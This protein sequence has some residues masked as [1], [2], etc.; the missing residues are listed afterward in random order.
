MLCRAAPLRAI[1]DAGSTSP[2][3]M[4]ISQDARSRRACRLA[5]PSRSPPQLP[6]TSRAGASRS[7][8]RSRPAAPPTRSRASSARS[9]PSAGSSPSSSR[10]ARARP[11]PPAAR[12]SPTPR[13]TATPCSRARPGPL[14]INRF[15]QKAF[16]FDPLQL[17]PITVMAGVP[18]VLAI[19]SS[20]PAKSVGE[21][22]AYAKQA[23]GRPELRIAGAGLDVA[24]LGRAVPEPD[25][26]SRWCM[27]PTRAARPR[28]PISSAAIST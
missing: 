10:T 4:M 3:S 21:L 20:L 9:S 6:P 11:E 22:V 19:R 13:P 7:S 1:R 2:G 23:E 8:S 5:S 24:S 14:V 17:T 28:S 27:C 25:R 18:T 16:S 12:P 15:V 26:A